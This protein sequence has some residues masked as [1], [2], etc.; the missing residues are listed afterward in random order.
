MNHSNHSCGNPVL[1]L[2]KIGSCLWGLPTNLWGMDLSQLVWQEP[3]RLP[4]VLLGNPARCPPHHLTS[5]KDQREYPA[6]A[7]AKWGMKRNMPR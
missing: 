6:L 7:C 5:E 2:L 1:A 4:K 3:D